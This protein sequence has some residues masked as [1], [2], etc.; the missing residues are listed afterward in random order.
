MLLQVGKYS[1]S[2]HR[3]SHVEVD[4][5]AG[6]ITAA[7]QGLGIAELPNY[8]NILSLNLKKVLPNIKGEN[9]PLCFMYHEN[10]KQSKKIQALY[11]YLKE[12]IDKKILLP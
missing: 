12:V 6:M 8:Q 1:T 10:R 7:L 4:S 2:P 11:Q 5:L 9:I 3:H